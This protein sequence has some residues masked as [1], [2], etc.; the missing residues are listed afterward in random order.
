MPRSWKTLHNEQEVQAYS[1]RFRPLLGIAPRIYV[2]V[3]WLAALLAVLF[4]TL[5]LPGLRFYGSHVDVASWPS[6][7]AVWV[8]DTLV[9]ATPL[10]VPVAAGTRRVR[11]EAPGFRMHDTTI[12]VPGR[13]IASALFPRRTSFEVQLE[14]AEAATVVERATQEFAGWALDVPA[15]PRV[16]IPASAAVRAR[17]LVGNPQAIATLTGQ[18]LAHAHGD[19]LAEVVAVA[20]LRARTSGVAGISGA[21]AAFQALEDA[22]VDLAS[23]IR[24]EAVAGALRDTRWYEDRR[25]NADTQILTATARLDDREPGQ[26]ATRRLAGLTFAR[27]PPGS[28]VLGYGAPDQSRLGSVVVDRSPRWLM[29]AEVTRAEFARF[30]TDQPQWSPEA[31]QNLVTQGL[32]DDRYL[33]DWP[34]DWAARFLGPSTEAQVPVRYVSWFAADAFAQ[35]ADRQAGPAWE[36]T[37]PSRATW[38]RAAYIDATPVP[39]AGAVQSAARAAAGVY[40]LR[41]MVGN[42]WEWTS[43]WYGANSDV[44]TAEFGVQRVVVGGS[45]VNREVWPAMAGSQGPSATTPYLGFRLTAADAQ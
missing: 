13:L 45:Y 8:D 36:I 1:F 12:E 4:L 27:I 41:N 30:V 22:G 32:A 31:R 17:A 43:D 7:A 10:R 37:L 23:V 24:N 33:E 34:T 26:S 2:P 29:V 28:H 11:L 14:S 19:R 21:V 16:H 15:G 42:L 6:G 38:E 3:F 40:G 25:A 20:Q 44:I 9:G 18:L 35:W 39:T 5:V